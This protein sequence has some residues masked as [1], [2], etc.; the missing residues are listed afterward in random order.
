MREDLS[1]LIGFRD[2]QNIQLPFCRYEVTGS[3]SRM[4]HW[5]NS[6]APL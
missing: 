3:L 6:Q 4:S 2:P 5:G 1:A